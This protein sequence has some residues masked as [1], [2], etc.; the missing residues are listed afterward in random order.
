MGV[1]KPGKTSRP[2]CWATSRRT[3]SNAAPCS[4]SSCV[5]DLARGLQDLH[6]VGDDPGGLVRR[7]AGDV[8]AQAVEATPRRTPGR[9]R[10]PSASRSRRSRR[11]R[12]RPAG[13]RAAPRSARAGRRCRAWSPGSG[14]AGRRSSARAA[15]GWRRACSAPARP[16]S[17]A[18]AGRRSRPRRPATGRRGPSGPVP[19]SATAFGIVPKVQ[20]VWPVRSSFF[21]ACG[22]RGAQRGAD[23]LAQRG[24]VLPGG[25]DL[26]VARPRRRT[27]SSGGSGGGS[28][29][30]RRAGCARRAGP[31]SPPRARRSSG[32]WRGLTFSSTFAAIS[33]TGTSRLRRSFGRLRMSAMT[34]SARSAGTSHSNP[35]LL[36]CG[37]VLS[38]TWTVT[39]SCSVPGSKR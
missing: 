30:R 31:R 13:W 21:V 4:W 11:P 26:A 12:A 34:S 17:P 18:R 37:R 36:S 35:S 19:G 16:R 22:E 14:A 27:S 32:C 6:H 10:W 29:P 28:G 24:E 39:P 2:S 20:V 15:C 25:D 9:R 38:G 33:G 8:V 23:L 1:M 3:G 7:V 5:A